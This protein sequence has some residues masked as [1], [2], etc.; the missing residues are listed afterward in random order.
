ML[1]EE[2]L[3]MIPQTMVMKDTGPFLRKTSESW[4]FMFIARFHAGV[5]GENSKTSQI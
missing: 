4:P 1:G 5:L 3:L 2:A